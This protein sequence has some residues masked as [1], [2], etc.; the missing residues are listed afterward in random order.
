MIRLIP[1]DRNLLDAIAGAPQFRSRYGA[2][3]AGHLDVAREVVEQTLVFEERVAA[4]PPWGG[5][6]VVD[7]A[8]EV[9]V[10]T[11]GFKGNPTP[12]AT[13]EI[14]Y[15]T[16]PEYEGRGFATATARELVRIAAD[17]RRVRA[18]LAHT[19][20]ERNSSTRVLEK[21]GFAFAGEVIDPEDGR[22]WRWRRA[23]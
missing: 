19:L 1:I 6:L 9:V 13:V 18:V 23:P 3:I 16:F 22:V 21:N 5:Y 20:P 7:R 14:A 4:S 2:D 15:F 10:G 17:A 8:D 12:D 11:C